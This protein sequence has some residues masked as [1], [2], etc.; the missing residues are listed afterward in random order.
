MTSEPPRRSPVPVGVGRIV[1]GEAHGSA[2]KSARGDD[3]KDFAGRRPGGQLRLALALAVLLALLMASAARAATVTIGSPLTGTFTSQMGGLAG[4]WT[5]TG[6][7]MGANLIS[8]SDGTIVRWRIVGATG[9][10]FYLRVLTPV[11]GTTYT[12]A[13][14][15][16]AQTP[17][18]NGTET[19]PA[20]LPIRAGQIVGFDNANNSDMFGLK[21]SAGATYTDW[22]PALADGAT[23]PYTNPYGANGEI[24]FN[25]DVRYCVVPALTG[26]KIGAAR[27]ALTAADCAVGKISRPTNKARRKKAKFVRAVSAVAGSSISDTAPIDL[28]LGKKG[29]KK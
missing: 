2:C 18:T 29:H 21:I 5:N 8:P 10:P 23:L 22:N 26:T 17:S 12:G 20:N 19:F 4:T 6:L 13:G 11:V 24:G 15:G 3:I 16:P 9:G 27:Q 25:A 28:V 14:T 7:P 1:A